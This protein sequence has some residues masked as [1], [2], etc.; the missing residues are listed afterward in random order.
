MT[1]ERL[2][3]W[4][5]AAAVAALLITIVNIYQVFMAKTPANLE[6]NIAVDGGMTANPPPL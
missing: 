3:G 4:L 5:L 6:G 2:Q 1:R